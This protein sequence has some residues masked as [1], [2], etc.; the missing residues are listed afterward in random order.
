MDVTPFL[1]PRFC[2]TNACNPEAIATGSSCTASGPWSAAYSYDAN[3]NVR[4]RKDARG[5]VTNY[6]YDALNRVTAKSY[7]NDPANTPVLSYGYDTEYPWQVLHNENHP[8]GH[9]NGIQATVGTTNVATWASGDYDQRGNLTGYYT[10]LGSNVQGCPTALGVAALISYNLNDSLFQVAAVSG[11]ATSSQAFGF[12][13]NFDNAG[14]LT[15]I[16]TDIGLNYSSDGT[17]STSNAFSGP[18]FYPGGA[19]ETANLAS[20][21]GFALS[22]TYDNRGR[23]TG[24]IDTNRQSELNAYGVE[25]EWRHGNGMPA[26]DINDQLSHP[27]DSTN[28]NEDKPILPDFPGP[29]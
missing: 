21:P 9:L 7:T 4:T 15:L 3:G 27:P 18:T 16:Q 23:I 12:S 8:V 17:V 20:N 10:C 19:V 2:L 29:Q 22:R 24:E 11:S 5:I 25:N 28:P 6:T 1:S 26:I 14:R 13:Y